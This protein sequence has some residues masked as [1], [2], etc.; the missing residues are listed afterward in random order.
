MLGK[1]TNARYQIQTGQE[2][3]FPVFVF[4]STTPVPDQLFDELLHRLSGAELKVLLY[5]VRRTFG[6][7]K[8][9]DN[10]SLSQLICG[11][12]TKDGRTL[13]RGTGLGKASVARAL[14]SLEERN[15][16]QRTRRRSDRKEDTA[17]AYALN[18]LPPVSQNETPPVSKWNTGVSHQ[19]DTQQ[20][21]RQQTVKQQQQKINKDGGSTSGDGQNI[22]A[23][24]IDRGIEKNVAQHLVRKY[25]NQRIENNIDW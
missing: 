5:I 20:T 24:L 18:I 14:K 7:K 1:A 3:K 17:T 11:I 21:A 16:I 13:D 9:S 19:R 22:A 15:I 23:A 12:R 8:S 4:P 25:N 2:W 10:I 6:F